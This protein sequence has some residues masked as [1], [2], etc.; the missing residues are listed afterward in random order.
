MGLLFLRNEDQRTTREGKHLH[1]ITFRTA[2]TAIRE[3]QAQLVSQCPC[4]LLLMGFVYPVLVGFVGISGL[5]WH[6]GMDLDP[7]FECF[8]SNVSFPESF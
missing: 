6:L 8:V 2:G 3:R 7:D 4:L 5:T 1:E